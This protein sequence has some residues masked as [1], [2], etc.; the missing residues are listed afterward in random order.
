MC[1]GPVASRAE[2]KPV[3]LDRGKRGE[4]CEVRLGGGKDHKEQY[5]LL[6]CPVFLQ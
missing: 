2:R 4:W 3:C 6:S 5:R 1:K